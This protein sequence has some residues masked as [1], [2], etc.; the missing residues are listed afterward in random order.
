MDETIEK[1]RAYTD[2]IIKRIDREMPVELKRFEA[3]I[4]RTV[5]KVRGTPLDKLGELYR[6]I[7]K[8]FDF[9]GKY[10]PCKQGCSHCCYY[11]IGGSTGSP[12]GGGRIS[13]GR[14]ADGSA[15]SPQAVW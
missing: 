10:T 2:A 3:G 12:Q 4:T 15:G 14:P 9:F 11:K 6:C 13:D 1:S 8:V 5:M 7:D